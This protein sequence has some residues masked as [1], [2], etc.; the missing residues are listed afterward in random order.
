MRALDERIHW[1]TGTPTR[2]MRFM[3]VAGTVAMCVA[4]TEV[5]YYGSKC[6]VVRRALSARFAER[7]ADR[8][9]HASS[10]RSRSMTQWPVKTQ[11]CRTTRATFTRAS[12]SAVTQS[13]W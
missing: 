6:F 2:A 4:C 5:R 12:A 13:V 11:T 9:L 10:S 8:T 3:L 7:G 1:Q